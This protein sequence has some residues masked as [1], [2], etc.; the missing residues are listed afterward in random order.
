MDA[1]RHTPG[2]VTHLAQ[3]IGRCLAT[4]ACATDLGWRLAELRSVPLAATNIVIIWATII[5]YVAAVWLHHEWVA[6]VKG[7][8]FVWVSMAILQ[9][10]ITAMNWGRP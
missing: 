2:D 9:L 4:L 5:W 6:L 8:Y 3:S 1:D 10:S 7:P